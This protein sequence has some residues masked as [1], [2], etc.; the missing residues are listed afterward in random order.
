M[1]IARHVRQDKPNVFWAI[2][3]VVSKGNTVFIR[4]VE[5]LFVF[6]ADCNILLGVWIFRCLD[7]YVWSDFCLSSL[8][9][10][11]MGSH[12][13]KQHII[14]KN[15]VLSICEFYAL[16]VALVEGT[17]WNL[18]WIVACHGVFKSKHC[19]KITTLTTVL[20]LNSFKVDAAHLVLSISIQKS[21]H[22]DRESKRLIVS[23][24]DL[25][26]SG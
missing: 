17:L 3:L 25:D 9:C 20:E 16:S 24:Y 19:L 26:F 6:K 13:I 18:A 8:N 11:D 12:G 1:L 10:P 2:T 15:K 4:G 14:L 5:H 23:V 21:I 7:H 22:K